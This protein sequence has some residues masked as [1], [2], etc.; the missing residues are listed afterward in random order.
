MI[1]SQICRPDSTA[2]EHLYKDTSQDVLDT[3]R[4][5]AAVRLNFDV[6]EGTN[7]VPTSY[8]VYAAELIKK[9]YAN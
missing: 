4:I 7:V 2:L 6:P 9:Y 3:A 8:E 1:L 5:I